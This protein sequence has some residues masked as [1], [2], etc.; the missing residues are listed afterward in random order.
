MALE[1]EVAEFHS[2]L[3]AALFERARRSGALSE[4]P[5]EQARADLQ[6]AAKCLEHAATLSPRLPSVFSNLG[7]V[8]TAQGDAEAALTAFDRALA[9]DGGDVPTLYNRAAAL[10]QLGRHEDCLR[11]LE[12]LLEV[13]PTFAPAKA[14]RENTL[15]RLGAAVR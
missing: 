14:S 2:N 10:S 7:L 15:K 13:D 3:G 9:L 5:P 8:R 6:R 11:T 12:R 4:A 1:P